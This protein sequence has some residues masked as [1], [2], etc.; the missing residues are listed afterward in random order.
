MGTAAGHHPHRRRPRHH[1]DVRAGWPPARSRPAGSSA[2]I[3]V[4]TVANRQDRHR[5][6]GSRRAGH[7]P[8]RL[9]RHRDQPLRR[10]RAARR[11][12]G[13][14]RRRHG[15]LRAQPD[16]AAAVDPAARRGAAGLA[17][18]LPGRRAHWGSAS[19]FAYKSQ[20]GDLRRDPRILQPANRLRPARRQLRPASR[21]TAAVAG[22]ARATAA[23]TTATRS[24]TSTTASARTSSS[25]RTGI[26]R[27]WRSPPPSRRAVFHRAPAHGRRRAARRRLSRSCSTPA[28]C[29]TSGTP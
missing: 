12:V 4:A 22:A 6:P 29:S 9:P 25:T 17:A 19:D 16:P 5:R 13:R 11:A 3:P 18:D 10:H 24:A 8:G 28:G 23:T 7:H 14:V 2:P 21:D 27:G 1:R 15:Q 20:R 26:S